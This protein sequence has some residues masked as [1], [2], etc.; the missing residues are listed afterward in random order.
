MVGNKEI[1]VYFIKGAEDKPTASSNRHAALI[2]MIRMNFNAVVLEKK[3]NPQQKYIYK[4]INGIMFRLGLMLLALNVPKSNKYQKNVIFLFS[5]NAF[6]GLGVKII[7]FL[8]RNKLVIERN[9]FPVAIREN[10]KLKKFLFKNLILSWQY[11]LYDGLFLMTEELILFYSKYKRK[12]CIIEKLPMTVDME[13]FKNIEITTQEKYI[14][15]TGSLSDNK[16][17]INHL[18]HAFDQVKDNLK[19]INLKLAGGK[20]FEVH[21]LQKYIQKSGLNNRIE[22]L[23]LISKEEVPSFI[24]NA[25][26]LVLARPDSKQAQGGFPTKLGEYLATGKPVIVTKVGEIPK[27]LQEEDVFFIDPKN[28]E[29]ELPEILLNLFSNYEDA[30]KIG[31]N[32]RNK[33]QKYFSLDNNAERIATLIKKVANAQ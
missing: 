17:G 12:N 23:G 29:N 9:E 18:I 4:L 21:K 26:A 11:K 2:K 14:A 33:A 19:N 27:Y 13:R 30:L 15:Y 25:M 31:Q 8:K 6:V 7:C 1:T 3:Y 24:Q 22:L 5:I 28:I 20:S 32:G 16:D 10:N